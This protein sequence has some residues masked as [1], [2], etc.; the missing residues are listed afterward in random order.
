MKNRFLLISVIV[1]VSFDVCGQWIDKPFDYQSVL[2]DNP[3]V[4]GIT[5]DGLLRISYIN[6]Y[7]SNG[8]GFHSALLTYDSYFHS[9]H[10]SAAFF[11]RDDYQGDMIN[12]LYCGGAYSYWFR[13]GRDF[14]I[15]AGLSAAVYHRGFHF[16]NAVLPDMIGPAGGMSTVSGEILTDKG[17][18]VFDVSAG[19]SFLAGDYY[20]GLSVAH[21]SKPDISSDDYM[22]ENVGR[23]AVAFAGRN[24]YFGSDDYL[25]LA[26]VL[27][28]ECRNDFFSAC[29][30]VSGEIEHF[31][32]N[33]AMA[34]DSN[35]DLDVQTGF[36]VSA[37]DFSI[38]YSYCFNVLSPNDELPFSL[39]HRIGFFV[40]LNGFDKRKAL[41]TIKFPKI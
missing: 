36:S 27:K 32:L 29:L 18:T 17:K 15:H 13:A 14:Y 35:S 25:M 9:I 26:P 34:L 8:Y 40:R 11:L 7:P 10:G 5:G 12:T 39:S 2:F 23:K 41:K 22:E 38:Q 16:R 3:S 4:A 30:G 21:L 1:F 6:H 31:A 33:V 20:G 37:A 19:I 28:V 24:F